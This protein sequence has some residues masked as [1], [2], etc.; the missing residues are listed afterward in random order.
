MIWVCMTVG[1]SGHLHLVLW[2]LWWPWNRELTHHFKSPGL[3]KLKLIAEGPFMRCVREAHTSIVC[4]LFTLK[5][6]LDQYSNLELAPP[7]FEKKK[8]FLGRKPADP[9]FGQNSKVQNIE[10][11]GFLRKCCETAPYYFLL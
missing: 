4:P 1:P 6:D 11:L 5:I 10:K 7:N 8:I 9:N 2:S 3:N